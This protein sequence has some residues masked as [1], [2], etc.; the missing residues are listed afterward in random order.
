MDEKTTDST[1]LQKEIIDS[2]F[3]LGDELLIRNFTWS[4]EAQNA[5][6]DNAKPTTFY[7]K[8]LFP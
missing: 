4:D 3:I 5:T 8:R 6:M 1:D 7:I 2:W